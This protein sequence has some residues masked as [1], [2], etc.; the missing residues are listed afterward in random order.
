[1][2]DGGTGNN[3]LWNRQKTVLGSRMRQEPVPEPTPTSPKN[4]KRQSSQPYGAEV[5]DPKGIQ[6]ILI[7]QVDPFAKLQANG[8]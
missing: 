5:I 1:M 7:Y 3:R 2:L 6:R 4:H 8:R